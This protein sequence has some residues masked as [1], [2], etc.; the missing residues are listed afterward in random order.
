MSYSTK[1]YDMS[2][3]SIYAIYRLRQAQS[4][5]KA[6]FF[7]G[8]PWL[9]PY[10]QLVSDSAT[11]AHCPACPNPLP[12]QHP[13]DCEG[14]LL[15]RTWACMNT[16]LSLI[17]NSDAPA[18]C[19]RGMCNTECKRRKLKAIYGGPTRKDLRRMLLGKNC[20]ANHLWLVSF[21]GNEPDIDIQGLVNLNT[22]S[23]P[24]LMGFATFMLSQDYG[25]G[26]ISAA[27]NAVILPLS[28]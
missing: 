9:R 3:R 10:L 19:L 4:E 11:W 7:G 17:C 25:A 16:A 1:V 6:T 5:C 26:E 20:S 27:G 15:S 24:P 21:A 18:V 14:E 13:F 2:L 8:P 23:L 28:R 22:L 12:Y